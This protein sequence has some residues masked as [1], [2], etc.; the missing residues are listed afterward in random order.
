MPWKTIRHQ[1]TNVNGHLFKDTVMFTMQVWL[2]L[3]SVTSTSGPAACRGWMFYISPTVTDIWIYTVSLLMLEFDIVS[4]CVSVSQYDFLLYFRVRAGYGN[5]WSVHSSQSLG[6][7]GGC[8]L[9]VSLIYRRMQREVEGSYTHTLHS[10]VFVY[11]HRPPR[12]KGVPLCALFCPHTAQQTSFSAK[13]SIWD[14]SVDIYSVWE[15]R[16]YK[17]RFKYFINNRRKWEM[18]Q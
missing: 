5:V 1:K 8:F 7:G 3:W 10:R 15:K 2:E 4:T 12:D 6:A 17:T 14:Q 11:T 16:M 18:N 9:P 13:E